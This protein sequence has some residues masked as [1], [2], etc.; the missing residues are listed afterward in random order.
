MFYKIIEDIKNNDDFDA[1]EIMHFM[2]I[3]ELETLPKKRVFSALGE[4]VDKISFINSG[5]MKCFIKDK[6]DKEVILNFY[7]ENDW[8]TDATSFHY[9]SKSK[10]QIETIE[11]SE[12]VTIRY[13]NLKELSSKFPKFEKTFNKILMDYIIRKNERFISNL[14]NS[15]K[16]K[17]ELFAEMHPDLVQRVSQKNIAYYLGI[18]PEFLSKMRGVK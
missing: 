4:D 15:A 16:E 18:T 2:S 7:K 10:F 8:I 3:L 9:Q 6:N 14:T 12:L 5:L 11:K 17:Y 13:K 1:I